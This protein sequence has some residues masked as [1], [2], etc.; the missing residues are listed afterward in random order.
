MLTVLMTLSALAGPRTLTV[1]AVDGQGEPVPSAAVIVDVEDDRHPVRAD[2]GAWTSSVLYRK[3][4]GEIALERGTRV[5]GWVVAPGYQPARL[6]VEVR[7]RKHGHTVTLAPMDTR[8]S[9]VPLPV[10]DEAED[11][12]RA[13]RLAAAALQMDDLKTADE[14]LDLA[15]RERIRLEGAPYVDATLAVLE[16]RT[17][18]AL[19]AWNSRFEATLQ[20]PS[21]ANHR[22]LTVSRGVTADLALDWR[23]YARG[24]KRSDQR[25]VA[26]CRTASGRSSRCD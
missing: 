7:K 2:S 10:A 6:D 12:R 19:S 5:L 15:D 11:V 14:R 24:A 16:L 21:D 18:V 25:A 20:D 3:G 23:D 26:L 9:S 13:L 1:T 4:G 8:A 17:L 22:A